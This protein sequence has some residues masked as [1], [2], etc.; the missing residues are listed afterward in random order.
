M[1]YKLCP[2]HSDTIRNFQDTVRLLHASCYEWMCK[3][4]EFRASVVE[5]P[6]I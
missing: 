1:M 6:E 4:C 2:E 3:L 5:I